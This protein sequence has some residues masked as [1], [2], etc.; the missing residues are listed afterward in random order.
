MKKSCST[1]IQRFGKSC[2]WTLLIPVKEIQWPWKP[3]LSLVRQRRSFCRCPK[4]VR[5]NAIALHILMELSLH[6]FVFLMQVPLKFHLWR[7]TIRTCLAVGILVRY[8][9]LSVSTLRLQNGCL[10]QTSMAI[11]SWLFRCRA[12]SILNPPPLWRIWR[13]LTRR[14]HMQ[15]LK[16]IPMA[17]ASWRKRKSRRKWGLFPISLLIWLFVVHRKVILPVLLSTPWLLLMRK[18]TSWIISVPNVKTVSRS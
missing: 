8:R 5:E 13:T 6:W 9:T 3:H 17:C 4:S 11:L 12:K 14:Q 15:Y 2:W 7:S 16:E 18:N 1:I 10:V